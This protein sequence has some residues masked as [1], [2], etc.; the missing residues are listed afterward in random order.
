VERSFKVVFVDDSNFCYDKLV[1]Y[2]VLVLPKQ[3]CSHSTLEQGTVITI[4]AT[5]QCL[6]NNIATQYILKTYSA[7]ET[8]FK[9]RN[10]DIILTYVFAPTLQCMLSHVDFD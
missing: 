1:Q 6:S 10:K 5:Y 3:A 4:I 2:F 7:N 8:A 9:I